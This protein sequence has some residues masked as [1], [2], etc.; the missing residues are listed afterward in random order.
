MYRL[1]HIQV[2]FQC[3]ASDVSERPCVHWRISHICN[4]HSLSPLWSLWC[5]VRWEHCLKVFSQL[6]HLKGF[7]TVWILWCAARLW[8]LTESLSTFITFIWF[9]SSVSSVMNNKI[10]AL[11]EGLPT[12]IA[13]IWLFSSVNSLVQDK[14]WAPLE[15][16]PTLYIH[17]DSHHYEFSYANQ[18]GALIKVSST[19]MTYIRFL[20]CMNS[21]MYNKIWTWLKSF[22]HSLHTYGFFPIWILWCIIRFELWLKVFPHSLHW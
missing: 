17:R 21:L 6:L 11:I 4:I 22:P 1:F 10:W 20:S 8:A 7:S 9:I 14:V 18:V 2:P 13:Y 12:F 19:F 15:G 5:S 3:V 16:L